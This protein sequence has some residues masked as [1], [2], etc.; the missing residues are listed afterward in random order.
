MQTIRLISG[1]DV[2]VNFQSGLNLA[3]FSELFVGTAERKNRL[4]VNINNMQI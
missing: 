3:A 1:H 2:F 4:L